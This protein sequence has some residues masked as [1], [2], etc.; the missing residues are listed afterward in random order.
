MTKTRRFAARRLSLVV[1]GI[2]MMALSMALLPVATSS[3]APGSPLLNL[4]ADLTLR[5]PDGLGVHQGKIKHVWLIILENK[6]YDASFTGLNNN[7]YLWKTLPSQGV[8]LKN[9]YGTGHFSLDN[10]ISLV[11]GQATQPDT[12]SDCPFYDQ[13]GG[14]VDMSGSLES[15]P[16]YGQVVSAAGPNAAPGTNGCVYPADVPTLFNQLDAAHVSWKGYA[17]DLNNPDASSTGTLSNPGTGQTHSV[18]VSSCG[19]PYATP[20]PTGST[21]YPNP[22][23]ANATDQYV[24]KHFPFPWFDSILTSGDCNSAHIT[25]LFD[26]SNGLYHDLQSESTTPAFSWIT[27][28]NCSDAHDAVCHGNNLSGGFSDPNTPNPPV[29]YTGGLYASDLFLEHVIPEIEASP[30]FKDGGLIDVTFDEAFPPFTYSGNSFSNS[31]TDTP[32]AS[33]SIA[34][35]SA[36]ETIFGKGY[37]YE[38]TGPNTPLATDSKGNQLD[39]GPGDN[40]YI[41][42]PANCVAQT[43]PAQPAGT[44]L[45]GGGSNSPGPRTDAVTASADVDDRRQRGGVDGRRPHRH[46]HRDPGRLLRR[47]GDRH[48]RRADG[49]EPEPRPGGHR[50][51]R[52]GQRLGHP[53]PDDRTRHQRH[54]RRGDGRHRPALR[55][56]RPHHRRRGHG[57]RAHQPVHHAGDGEQRLLQPLQLA[58]HYGG[59]LR[60]RQGV[61]RS[62]WPGAHRLRGPD[63]SGTLRCRRVQQP[64][65]PAGWGRQRRRHHAAG[66]APDTRPRRGHGCRWAGLGAAPARAPGRRE[67][68][69]ALMSTAARA[70]RPGLRRVLLLVVAAAVVAVGVWV[71]VAGSQPGATA[72]TA[73]YGSLPSWLPKAS[74]PVGRVVTATTAHPW[75]AIE[76]DTVRAELRGGQALVTAVGPAVPEEGQFPVPPTTPCTFTVTFAHGAGTVPLRASDFTITDE[77]GGLHHPEVTLQGG[78]PVPAHLTPGRTVTLTMSEVLPTGNGSLHWAPTPRGSLVSWDFD[79]EI[80]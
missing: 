17:Q 55:R 35:D 50:L 38:P 21:A 71:G 40:S 42:R 66:A 49:A 30:A 28:D 52:A 26:P 8:L 5:G 56:H 6:S 13:V 63:R 3:A 69:T 1:A 33:T 72:G 80:D 29:N 15:N 77:F 36:A 43:V 79:V 78:G 9:Y 62:R 4:H 65:G 64:R 54:P 48:P 31:T 76:G 61:A 25:N 45:L 44:C 16:N 70:S 67:L 74:V 75:L 34:S 22:G 7:T 41:D 27:P 60:G 37:H 32:T 46:R 47:P 59:H 12:Q 24:P 73:G 53:G 57:Q 51:V 2:G 23:S 14:T 20:G 58:A 10:Y 19:A 39:P 18:G 11:S 68:T